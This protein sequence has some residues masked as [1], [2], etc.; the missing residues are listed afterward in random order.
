MSDAVRVGLLGCGNVGSA[1]VGLLAREA[2][3][4]ETRTGIRLV[5]TRVAVRDLEKARPAE[6]DRAVLTTDTKELVTADDVDVVVEIMGVVD[7]ADDL[8]RA[9]LKA[10]KPVVTANKEL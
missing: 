6:L 2:D 3:D 9:A 4:I 1:L 10:G 7:P 8:L 5:I